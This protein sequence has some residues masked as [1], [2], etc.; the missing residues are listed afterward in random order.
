MWI[1]S[2]VVESLKKIQ[3]HSTFES[4]FL[5]SSYWKQT[6]FFEALA[7]GSILQAGDSAQLFIYV[8]HLRPYSEILLWL[9][10][11]Q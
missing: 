5:G 3:G 10:I 8:V 7:S 6:I 4:N 9:R 1:G 2:L 11:E